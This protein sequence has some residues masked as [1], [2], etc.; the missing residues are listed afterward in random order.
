MDSTFDAVDAPS[1]DSKI[2]KALGMVVV[3]MTE[4]DCEPEVVN[5]ETGL[6]PDGIHKSDE[7]RE[8][9]EI[10]NL[11][12]SIV[13]E[14]GVSEETTSSEADAL[15]SPGKEDDRSEVEGI[16][17]A[18][19]IV[20]NVEDFESIK[21]GESIETT[22]VPPKKSAWLAAWLEEAAYCECHDRDRR[23]FLTRRNTF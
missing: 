17:V 23:R 21:T 8:I 18:T 7:D 12:G 1:R 3:E 19:E 14:A 2:G 13:A 16:G 6:H 22:R 20:E 4:L 10:I 9:N 15:F 11:D 5:T